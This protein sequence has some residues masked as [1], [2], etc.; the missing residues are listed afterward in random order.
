MFGYL[1][2]ITFCSKLSQSSFFLTDI[3]VYCFKFSLS[4]IRKSVFQKSY[5]TV[6][7]TESISN[8]VWKG[9]HIIPS[10]YVHTWIID[11]PD[12]SLTKSL[13]VIIL[14][15]YLVILTDNNFDWSHFHHYFANSNF[16]TFQTFV[17]YLQ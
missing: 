10:M 6:T 11:Q 16:H 13:N 5:A 7:R 1:Y 15:K 14:I 8:I 9:G 17:I 4:R 3:V 2:R 12:E